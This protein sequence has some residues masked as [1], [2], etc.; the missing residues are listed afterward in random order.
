MHMYQEFETLIYYKRF[1]TNSAVLLFIYFLVF[2]S[3][4][5]TAIVENHI[6]MWNVESSLGPN[7]TFRICLHA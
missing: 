7:I 6:L 2:V 4:N 3:F 5:E 1:D